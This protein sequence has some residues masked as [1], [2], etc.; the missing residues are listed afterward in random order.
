ML[1]QQQQE[2]LTNQVPNEHQCA[3]VFAT[4]GRSDS[5]GLGVLRVSVLFMVKRWALGFRLLVSWFLW[6][7]HWGILPFAKASC[8]V[9][10]FY[11]YLCVC[12]SSLIYILIWTLF[13]Y[14]HTYYLVGCWHVPAVRFSTCCTIIQMAEIPKKKIV[15]P[16][17]TSCM[18]S[19][20][21]LVYIGKELSRTSNWF[22]TA[23]VVYGIDV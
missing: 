3:N 15:Y 7:G 6:A 11:L 16:T 23:A 17:W 2:R 1:F 4:T 22:R 5:S 20:S 12:I 19:W 10:L 13:H 8:R 21:S 9:I 14:S 18:G